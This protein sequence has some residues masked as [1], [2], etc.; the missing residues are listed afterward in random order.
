MK[1]EKIIICQECGKAFK[2]TKH[3]KPGRKYCSRNCYQEARLRGKHKRGKMLTIK[4]DYCGNYFQ[5]YE[6]AI[7]SHNFC[8]RTCFDKWYKNHAPSPT[9]NQRLKQSITMRK[10]RPGEGKE[11][12]KLLGKYM[13]RTL[14]E[15]KLGR[16]LKPNEIIHHINGN[17]FDNR[18][19]NLQIVTRAEHNRIHFTKN[20]GGDQ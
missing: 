6:S 16:K 3:M 2:F 20:K 9:L 8:S 19:E 12:K 4:C 5:R 10:S 17:K 14:M 18:I 13:H 7:Q 15:I 11:Y 1:H